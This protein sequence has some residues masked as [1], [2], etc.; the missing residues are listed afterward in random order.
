MASGKFKVNVERFGASTEEDIAKLIEERNRPNT[1]RSTKQC[2]SIL[3]QYLAAKNLSDVELLPDADLPE[4][5]KK[6]YADARKKDGS[7]YHTQSLKNIRSGI[8]RYFKE[9]HKIDIIDDPR[10]KEANMSF[11]GSQVRAKRE[12]RGVRRSTPV[13]SEQDMASLAMY[14]TVDHLKQP[15]PSVLQRNVMFN[16]IYYLCRRGQENLY[17][18]TKDWFQVVTKPTG[19]RFVAQV[20]DEMDK[21]HTE[22][23]YNM[24]NEGRMYEVAGENNFF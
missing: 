21:N 23:D 22:N 15:N 5:L 14:F 13:I 17:E 4:I 18:M 20:K 7:R 19:E 10:F 11:Q 9:K 6:F 24:T 12:G 3:R 1:N 16:I 2:V 8:N